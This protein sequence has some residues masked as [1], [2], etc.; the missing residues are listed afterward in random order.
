MIEIDLPKAVELV[1]ACIAEKPEGFKYQD[2]DRCEGSCVNLFV[3]RDEDGDLSFTPACLVG[4]VIVKAGINP[5]VMWWRDAARG[6]LHSVL[7]ALGNLLTVTASAE[8]YLR[9]IQTRQDRGSTWAQAHT[10]ALEFVLR[11]N[12]SADESEL[13]WMMQA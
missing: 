13:A 6:A 11:Y 4:S 3:E 7:V 5:R 10:D 9:T 2:Y 1:L 12:H 8:D